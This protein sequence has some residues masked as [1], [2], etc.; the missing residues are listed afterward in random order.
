MARRTS[1]DA[2]P[3]GPSTKRNHGISD[4]WRSW[5]TSCAS[6]LMLPPKTTT[7]VA[8]SVDEKL[9]E[10]AALL[11]SVASQLSQVIST[12]AP[13]GH[14][15]PLHSRRHPA[16]Y[17]LRTAR[18]KFSLRLNLGGQQQDLGGC[19]DWKDLHVVK[20]SCRETISLFCFCKRTLN[21][22]LL[23]KPPQV[24]VALSPVFETASLF[25]KVLYEHTANTRGSLSKKN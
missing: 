9:R 2:P 20:T 19:P 14:A 13:Q 23:L 21:F 7:L 22:W 18:I 4:S 15:Q 16:E 25:G 3:V 10:A 6:S 17:T 12:W 1:Q 11:V 8:K 24:F 5:R